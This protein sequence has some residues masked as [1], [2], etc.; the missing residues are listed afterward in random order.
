MCHLA[1]I[2]LDCAVHSLITLAM[3]T[4]ILV[5]PIPGP[6][7]DLTSDSASGLLQKAFKNKAKGYTVDNTT[8][9]SATAAVPAAATAASC[10]HGTLAGECVGMNC[11][12]LFSSLP[13]LSRFSLFA[14]ALVLLPSLQF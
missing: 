10:S 14:C 8:I 4:K 9:L 11:P 5:S 13:F 1:S 2:V 7:K 6:F 3:T 12:L